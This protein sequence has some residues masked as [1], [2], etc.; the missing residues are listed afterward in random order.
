MTIRIVSR[1]PQPNRRRSRLFP[2][3][4]GKTWSLRSPG[5]T[6]ER[7]PLLDRINPERVTT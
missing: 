2:S 3:P 6:R 7:D 4:K 5:V 1:V